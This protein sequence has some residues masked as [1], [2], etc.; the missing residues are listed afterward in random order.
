MS[1]LQKIYLLLCIVGTIFPYVPFGFFLAENG[2][3]LPLFFR[4]LFSNYISSFFALDFI[5]TS[6]VFWAF[7]FWEG[8]RLEMRSLWVYVVCH[9]TVGLSL[10]FPLFLWM[11]QRKLESAQ[12]VNI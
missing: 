2:L 11:R 4:E 7:L 3:N 9:L 5:I 8:S 10:G 12:V 6:F 1:R